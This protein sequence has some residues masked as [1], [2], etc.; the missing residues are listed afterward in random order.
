MFRRRRKCFS[1]TSNHPDL[2][3]ISAGMRIV[4]SSGTVAVGQSNPFHHC[5]R[6]SCKV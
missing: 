2:A 1:W 3:Y 5:F 4:E 6:S